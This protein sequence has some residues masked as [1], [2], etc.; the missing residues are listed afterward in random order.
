MILNLEDY[1]VSLSKSL[2]RAKW[3]VK[4]T[5]EKKIAKMI[6]EKCLVNFSIEKYINNLFL[7]SWK[8]I[9]ILKEN[10]IHPKNNNKVFGIEN[11]YLL[12]KEVL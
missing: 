10:W 2:K 8:L 11:I 4:K 3:E 7:E 9:N 6:E 12:D 5:K 1:G